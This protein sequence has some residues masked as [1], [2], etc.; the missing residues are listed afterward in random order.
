MSP[1]D[2]YFYFYL[3][4]SNLWLLLLERACQKRHASKKIVT[5]RYNKSIFAVKF[6]AVPVVQRGAENI[7]TKR[8][9]RFHEMWKKTGYRLKAAGKR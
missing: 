9:I 4:V 5:T 3:L 8:S 1:P 7:L 2:Y 6:P